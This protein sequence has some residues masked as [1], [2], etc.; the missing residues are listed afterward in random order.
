MIHPLTKLYV[1]V[2]LAFVGL[3]CQEN[4]QI[5]EINLIPA[6]KEL[7]VKE[8]VFKFTQNTRIC[9]SPNKDTERIAGFFQTELKRFSLHP[10]T[11][12]LNEGDLPK[13][14]VVFELDSSASL[15]PEAYSLSID[16]ERVYARASAPPGLFYAFQSLKQLLPDSST[17]APGLPALEINDAPRFGWRGMHLDVCRHFFPPEFV[18][19]YIDYLAAVKMNRFH[20]HLTDDQ[21]WRIEIKAYPK[22]TEI[23]SWRKE[24]VI[25]HAR[26]RPAKFDGQK[27]GGFYTQEDVKEI[28]KY[29]QD[30]FITIIPEIEMPGHAQAAI[31][32]YPFLGCTDDSVEVWTTWGVSPYIFNTEDTTFAFLK[33]VLDEVMTLFPGK[34]IHIGGD[35]AV[36]DQWKNSPRI[37]AQMKE[38]DLNDEHEMQSYFIQRIEKFVNAKGRIIIGWDEILEGGLAPNAVVMS[39]RG[40]KGGIAA[41]K[42]GHYVVMSPGTHCYFDHYQSENTENEPLAI[43]GFTDVE[44]VYSFEPVPPELSESESKYIL[45]AQANVWTEYIATPEHAEYMIFPRMLALSE[46]LWSPQEKRNYEDFLKRLKAY[47]PILDRKEINYAGH[48]FGDSTLSKPKQI[49]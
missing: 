37:Q 19:Q 23:G 31:A 40:T 24:T 6:P 34:Y 15:N 12:G 28:V 46:V 39:W 48:V 21:G 32:S 13:N 41:S 45:G 4:T 38:L 33:T 20:W 2:I 22:L 5:K 18:K 11:D 30:R 17:N 9:F 16:S 49:P 10:E 3:S 44:K 35:E 7:T 42:A 47:R 36:K 1:L 26:N 43:G 14:A 25:G 29:A 27:H 8:G